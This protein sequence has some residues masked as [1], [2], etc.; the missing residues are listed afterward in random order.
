MTTKRNDFNPKKKEEIGNK[1]CVNGPFID[2]TCDDSD[3]DDDDCK[4][5]LGP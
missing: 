1:R 3:R 2:L 5:T 4:R